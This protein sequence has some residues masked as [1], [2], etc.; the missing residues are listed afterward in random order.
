MPLTHCMH[1]RQDEEDEPRYDDCCSHA[2]VKLQRRALFLPP[3]L[4]A[5]PASDT[6]VNSTPDIR[7]LLPILFRHMPGREAAEG[8]ASTCRA[9]SQ[10]RRLNVSQLQITQLSVFRLGRD[11]ARRPLI[12]D[13][14]RLAARFPSVQRVVLH[15]PLRF[16]DGEPLDELPFHACRALAGM[17]F[18]RALVVPKGIRVGAEGA[19]A[20]GQRC[21]MLT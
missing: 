19:A 8:L 3:V 17:P 10:A 6:G 9:A 21:G 16:E 14:G 5:T 1:H 12:N 4:P 13:F 15:A 11:R 2:A 18:L 20:L 7:A